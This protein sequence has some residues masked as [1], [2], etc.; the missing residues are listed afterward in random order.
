MTITRM[1]D[2]TLQTKWYQ[3]AVASG[4]YLNYNGLNPISH[5]RNVITG[6]VDRAITFTNPEQR[7]ESL[8]CVR[9]LMKENGYP[10]EFTESIIKE[11]VDNFYNH[12]S[13]KSKNEIKMYIAAPYVHR[14]SDML[15]KS[16]S[17]HSLGLSCKATNT[18]KLSTR[19]HSKTVQK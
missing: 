6:V 18:R 4:R 8:K 3:K 7:P 11:R 12:N 9:N 15:K 5:K 19:F 1:E 16:L 13:K 17:K 2:G 14:L 10:T